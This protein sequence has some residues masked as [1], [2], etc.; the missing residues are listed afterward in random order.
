M[1]PVGFDQ[2]GARH[3][4]FNCDFLCIEANINVQLFLLQFVIHYTISKNL[5]KNLKPCC[6]DQYKSEV[7]QQNVTCD[8][9]NI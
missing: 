7:L 6:M 5:E 2:I 1:P 8:W 4:C 3:L 9:Y